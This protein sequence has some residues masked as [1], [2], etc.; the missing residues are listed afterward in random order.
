M[1]N[2]VPCS[3]GFASSTAS[4]SVDAS[5]CAT[6]TRTPWAWA[7]ASA[8]RGFV[9]RLERDPAL[10]VR[11]RLRDEPDRLSSDLLSSEDVSEGRCGRIGDLEHDAHP[12]AVAV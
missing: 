6:T 12:F 8:E 2:S 7:S 11:P 1:K 3:V 9:D 5:S 10:P 4:S